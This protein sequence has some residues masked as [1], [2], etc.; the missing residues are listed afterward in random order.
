MLIYVRVSQCM[1]VDTRPLVRSE[2]LLVVDIG[3][4]QRQLRRGIHVAK[5]HV[6]NG[7]AVLLAR[8]VGHEDTGDV[9]VVGPGH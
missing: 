4:R 7:V 9:R 8:H 1:E 3:H 6:G 2:V 5:Q